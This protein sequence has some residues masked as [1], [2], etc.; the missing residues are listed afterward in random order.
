MKVAQTLALFVAFVLSVSGCTGRRETPREKLVGI[1]AQESRSR[2]FAPDR[3]PFRYVLIS[4]AVVAQEN[5][6][7]Q[8]GSRYITVLMDGTAFSEPNLKILFELISK[9]HLKSV[10]LIVD[11]YTSLQQV[12]TPEEMD[13]ASVSEQ[14]YDT[15]L[16]RYPRAAYVRHGGDEFFRYTKHPPDPAMTTIVLR[17]SD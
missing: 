15:S 8:R 17:G 10:R 12:K 5:E 11:V 4:D 9:R 16:D 14:P 7:S 1:S 6:T 3:S 13:I 2:A